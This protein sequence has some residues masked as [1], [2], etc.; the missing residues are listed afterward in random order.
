M[1]LWRWLLA[2]S[3]LG[4]SV[5]SAAAPQA[6]NLADDFTRF[7]DATAALPLTARVAAFKRDFAPNLPSFYSIARFDGELTQEQYDSFIAKAIR[8][9]PKI[10]ADYVAK[11]AAFDAGL[12]R[13]NLSFVKAFPDFVPET[14]VYLLHSLGEMDGGTRTLDGKTALIFGADVIAQVHKGWKSEA[15]FFHHE[16]FH[17][18]HE[19][20]LGKCDAIWCSLW[21]EGLATHVAETLNPGSSEAE[22]LLDH[23]DDMAAQTRAALLPTLEALAPDLE[24]VDEKLYAD[25]FNGGKADGPLPRRRGYYIGLLVAR[26]IGRTRDLKTMANLTATEAQPLV[27]EAVQLLLSAE[28]TKADQTR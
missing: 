11:V 3:L 4:W 26:E 8:N 20:R 2:A 15:P 21:S 17:V 23:P 24:R 14:K 10:R 5:V 28:R 13:E 27:A 9:F 6:I 7:W 18:Y 22:L 25:L 19:P 12:E 16:L 1:T